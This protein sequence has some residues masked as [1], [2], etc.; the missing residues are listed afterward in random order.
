[1][2]KS[3]IKACKIDIFL[4]GIGGQGILLAS[5]IISQAGVSAGYDVKKSEVH[6]MSQRGGSVTSCVRLG[7]KVYSPLI[8]RGHADILLSLHPEEGRRHVGC[9]RKGGLLL[10]APA[11]LQE[12]LANPRTSN[13]ALVGILLACLDIPLDAWMEAITAKVPPK[14]LEDNKRAFFIGREIGSAN[15][16]LGRKA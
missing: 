12:K 14:Y 2:T 4:A 5:E 15:H 16:D 10:E 13:T 7:E 1:L 8:E 9:L 3:R 11:D 6:G